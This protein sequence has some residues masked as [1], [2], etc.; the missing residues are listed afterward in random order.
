MPESNTRRAFF[1]QES[2]WQSF[3]SLAM[4]RGTSVDAL[5]NEAMVS[6]LQSNG[7][8]YV[9]PDVPQNGGYERVPSPVRAAYGAPTGA[10]YGSSP[11]NPAQ[12]MAGGPGYGAPGMGAGVQN[13]PGMGAGVQNAPM[14]SPLGAR[15]PPP[16]PSHNY[17]RPPSIFEESLSESAGPR[18]PMVLASLQNQPPQYNPNAAPAFPPV[19]VQ[20][21]HDKQPPLYIIFAN[22]RYTVDKDKYIIGR[23]SQV[24]DL[25]IRDANISRKHCAVIYKNGAYYI[26]DLDSTNGIEFKGNRIDT[27]RIDE[28]DQFNICEFQFTFTYR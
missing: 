25:I 27:K 17:R 21:G 10:G 28:W 19:S 16:M 4:Q 24:A 14:G 7:M 13:A 15:V 20:P 11:M 5:I 26:K 9:S 6:Y 1:C 3:V 23:S 22:Q 18:K 2:L 12:G 8:G